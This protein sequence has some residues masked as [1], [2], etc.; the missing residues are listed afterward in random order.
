MDGKLFLDTARFLQTNGV[1]EA[2]YRSAVSRAYYSCFLPLRAIAFTYCSAIYRTAA[3]ISK[4]KSILH[5]KLQLYL[6]QSNLENVRRLGEDLS[7]LHAQR[8]GADYEMSAIVDATDAE[9]AIREAD[10]IHADIKATNAADIGKA[11]ENHIKSTHN[12]K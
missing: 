7:A 2:A 3:G 6:K 8:K 9:T 4:E 10:L 1:G 12:L 11:L 5:E